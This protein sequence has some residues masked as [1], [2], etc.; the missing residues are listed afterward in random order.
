LCPPS[1]ACAC[2]SRFCAAFCAGLAGKHDAL[3]GQVLTQM[4]QHLDFSLPTPDSISSHAH[5]MD[6]GYAA[7][8]ISLKYVTALQAL[9]LDPRVSCPLR[10]HLYCHVTDWYVFSSH[11]CR[12]E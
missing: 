7:L 5:F 10:C 11:H 1:R 2:V 9:M 8:G 4:R 6:Q 12:A 3:L